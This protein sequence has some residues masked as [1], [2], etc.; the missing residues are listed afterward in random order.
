[1]EGLRLKSKHLKE[2]RRFL[3]APIEPPGLVPHDEVGDSGHVYESVYDDGL[4]L[5]EK[6]VKLGEQYRL[7]TRESLGDN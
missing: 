6:G 7:P 2:I 4:D 1:V 5:G 3:S